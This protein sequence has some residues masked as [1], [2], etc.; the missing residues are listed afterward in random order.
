MTLGTPES[1]AGE[2]SGSPQAAPSETSP[3][4]LPSYQLDE[5]P[6]S[7][8][9]LASISEETQ[10][11]FQRFLDKGIHNIYSTTIHE[12]VKPLIAE[13]AKPSTA[14]F[15][16]CANLQI[17]LEDGHSLRFHQQFEHALRTF[18]AELSACTGII[19][20]RTLGAGL[21]L[22]TLSI[23][24]GFRWTSHLLCTADL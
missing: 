17:F 16:V 21:L 6:A 7:L 19:K 2:N 4:S 11:A 14:L 24:R 22:C 12:W 8:S 5:S 3:V 15:V 10:L 23:V 13:E 18:Q 20:A 9:S 1:N